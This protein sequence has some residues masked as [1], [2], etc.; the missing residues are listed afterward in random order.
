MK[1][2]EKRGI[3][4]FDLDDTLFDNTGFANYARKVSLKEMK[5][6][7]NLSISLND[8][9]NMFNSIYDS[10]GSYYPY[11]YNE[12]LYKLGLKKREVERLVAVAVLRYHEAKANLWRFK[13]RQVD[14]V[15]K[16]V[17]SFY[18]IGIIS[19]S[20][21]PVKQ[22]EKIYRLELEKYFAPVHVYITG[23]VGLLDKDT[24]FY[25]SIFDHYKE[26]FDPS[27]IFMVGDR[28]D[29]D[30]EE[31]DKAGFKTVRVATGKYSAGIKDSKADFVINEVA[32]LLGIYPF[33]Q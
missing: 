10:Y 31:A 16:R 21:D 2:K 19:S 30:I 17:S 29:S 25:K 33:S 1:N 20:S 18:E 24:Q 23:T 26:H 13:Y 22:W 6:E 9:I 8:L 5:D 4:F 32:D 27:H 7:G 28:E 14:K 3:V 12:L 15:L 11:H